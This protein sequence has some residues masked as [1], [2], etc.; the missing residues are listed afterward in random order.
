VLTSSRPSGDAG[1]ERS[2]ERAGSKGHRRRRR[3]RW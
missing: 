1:M 2:S 3:A